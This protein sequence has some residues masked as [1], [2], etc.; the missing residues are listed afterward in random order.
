MQI[1]FYLK[2]N[3]RKKFLI[4][5]RKDDIPIKRVLKIINQN[6][7]GFCVI[8]IKNKYKILT[9]GDFRRSIIN[10]IILSK[11]LKN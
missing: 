3:P 7:L 4:S 8:K 2:N 5:S 1:K 9:D 11:I 10:D 6:S